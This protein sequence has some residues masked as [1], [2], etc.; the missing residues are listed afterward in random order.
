MLAACLLLSLGLN[1]SA[2]VG[3]SHWWNGHE[4]TVPADRWQ[5]A[6]ERL[7]PKLRPDE[8]EP[9]EIAL[10]NVELPPELERLEE[11][12]E[13]KPKPE[14]KE[15][16]EPEIELEE[17]PE[18][19]PEP[20]PEPE[21]EEEQEEEKKDEDPPD[22][23]LTQMKM[24][25]QPDALDEE[26]EPLD[27]DYLSNIN[28]NTPENTQAK[29]TNLDKDAVDPKASQIEPSDKKDEGTA[30]EKEIAQDTTKES[31]LD[32]QAP[33]EKVSPQDERRSQNDPNPKSLLAMR[34]TEHLD[35]QLPQEE[36]EAMV[37]EADDGVMQA[38]QSKQSAQDAQERQARVIAK[39][40]F[41]KFKLS[42]DQLEALYGKDKV[43]K[44]D[45]ESAKESK[46][47]GVWE[48]QRERYQSPL[49]NFVPEVQPGNQTAL[50]SRKHPFARYIARIHRK[51]HEAWAW[52][53]L[54]QLDGRGRNH[55]LNDFDLWTRV[56]IVINADGTI[57]KVIT[58]RH[59]G[60]TAFDA[61]AREIIFAAGPFPDPPD[62]IRSPNGKVYMHWAFHRDQRACGTF[63]ADPFILDGSAGGGDRPDPNRRVRAGKESAPRRLKRKPK[64]KGPEG[65]AAPPRAGGHD[66]DHDHDHDHE[67]GEGEAQPAPTPRPSLSPDPDTMVNDPAAQKHAN[68]WLSYFHK[69]AVDRVVA[70]SSLPFKSGEQVVARTR[71][72][73]QAMLSSM[74]EE[75]EGKK[76]KKPK[77]FT[78]AGLRKVFGSVPAGVSEGSGRVYALTKVGGDFL[79]LVLEKKFGA[80]KVVGIAR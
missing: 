70:K 78:A 58:V 54:E 62:S 13:P 67:G 24:V 25:E 74:V 8:P 71:N 15:K 41:N 11:K 38:D 55:P 46:Q 50:R 51:I 37:D 45:T 72:E 79:I 73:L 3:V 17:L 43:A 31:R 18:L 76:P 69:K 6:L 26:S 14:E 48:K 19:P 2:I 66:H 1:A 42:Q 39:D 23:E 75:A 61:A 40:K 35:H 32:K 57:D 65:P 5:A 49:E 56:E 22:F 9:I 80:Y 30:N 63:G 33:R 21:K 52:G 7:F 77:L 60:K 59:S 64:A 34:E 29:I 12:D 10:E 68:A 44:R 47:E 16:P 53:F 20:E 28:N 36:H 4:R 27:A